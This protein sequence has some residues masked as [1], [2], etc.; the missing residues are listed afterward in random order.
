MSDIVRFAQSVLARRAPL[1]VPRQNGLGRLRFRFLP[2]G[3][4][5]K[6]MSRERRRRDRPTVRLSVRSRKPFSIFNA[7][8]D[9]SPATG[10]YSVCACIDF[11][12]QNDGPSGSDGDRGD[13]ARAPTSGRNSDRR[14]RGREIARE[15][16]KNDTNQKTFVHGRR[17]G[18][19]GTPVVRAGS[20]QSRRARHRTR[21]LRRTAL[22]APTRRLVSA[23]PDVANWADWCCQRDAAAARR[24]EISADGYK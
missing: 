15:Y 20:R 1:L 14:R 13:T 19:R 3:A 24:R 11:H 23:P 21:Y 2:H 7:V 17:S 8:V 16:G 6:T 4:D 9:D 12:G 10:T 18:R 22:S 5:Q